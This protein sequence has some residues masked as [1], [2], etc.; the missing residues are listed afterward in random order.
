MPHDEYQ[1]N[2][3]ERRDPHAGQ[4]EGKRRHFRAGN[5]NEEEGRTPEHGQKNEQEPVLGAH[6]MGLVR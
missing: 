2:Q 1:R 3:H 5:R 6:A 4:D